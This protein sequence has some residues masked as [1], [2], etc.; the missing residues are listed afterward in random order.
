MLARAVRWSLE[1]PRL[2][3]W[4][5]VG[6]LVWGALTL[7]DTPVD[8]LPE[9]AP[10][11]T[12]I[13]TEAPGLV[14]EQVETLVTHPIEA[15]ILG[16]AGVARVRSESVQGLSI[17]T[18]DFAPKADPAL[19]REAV[20]ERLATLNGALPAG[21]STPRMAPLTSVGGRI[22][23][24][25]FTSDKLN[26]MAL[27]DEVDWTIRPR[28]LAAAGVGR[29]SVYGGLI[30]RLEVRARPG[31]L[32]D[33]DLGFLDILNAV[34][35]ASSVA[36]AGFIDT[37]AQRVLIEPRGQAWTKEDVGAG[38]IQTPGSAP[39]RIED[40]ADV[41]EAPAPA[42]GD[43]L[44]MGKPGILVD[45]AKQYGAHTLQATRAAEAALG[46]LTP[47]LE[48][49]G[50]HV[51]ADLDRPASYD[52]QVVRGVAIDLAVGAALIAIALAI[53]MRDIRA[54]LISLAAIP[55]SI[56]GAVLAFRA[57]GWTVNAMTIGGV[58]VGLG[59]VIDDAV[60]DVENI[61]ANLREAQ[62]RHA[63][64][65]EAVLA[66]S[67]E[68][69]APVLY[70]TLALMVALL[71][72]LALPGTAGA[73]LAPLAG[74]AILTCAVS[75]VVAMLVT[76]ALA[77]ILLG[78]VGPSSEPHL[79][80][81]ARHAHGAALSRI[82]GR[83]WPLVIAVGVVAAVAVFAILTARPG[84]L[85]T[86]EDGQLANRGQPN[87]PG[88]SLWRSAGP[89]VSE[90]RGGGADSSRR[91]CARSASGLAAT[92]RVTMA[93]DPNAG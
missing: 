81:G 36:G 42:F 50:V 40:V 27:R 6:F 8:L 76:P 3:A 37:D 79:L 38:Q 92:P 70:A 32:S 15:A 41:S 74:A 47:A 35:R 5:C 58:A 84:P 66:A 7:R 31:D 28:L 56:V 61:A 39:V 22:L 45:I 69:R 51:R 10:A 23:R 68:I 60:I 48:A 54:T 63:S 21:A 33:S 80:H 53:F 29:V 67:V 26:A 59:V 55:L 24:I 17:V 11:E 89:T 20:T 16:A 19:V 46:F 71:P 62:S 85:P 18:V 13:H 93:G 78:H 57:L 82:G 91:E 1:R 64:R 52:I 87:P 34:K 72:V 49:Q 77:L 73:L 25:G 88:T 44:I 43:A 30:R 9:L 12:T 2:I 75:L 4:A 86:P 65:L 90:R 83:P 14:A